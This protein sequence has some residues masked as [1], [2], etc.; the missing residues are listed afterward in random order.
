MEQQ[1][2]FFS[3]LY[4]FQEVSVLLD[5]TSGQHE[6]VEDCEVCCNPMEFKITFENGELQEF[7][8]YK[9]YE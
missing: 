6:Y 2:Y 7:E 8:V 3:C 5:P 1:E 4:C 9:P